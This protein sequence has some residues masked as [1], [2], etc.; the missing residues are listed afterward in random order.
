MGNV[1]LCCPASDEGKAP[2]IP[3]EHVLGTAATE[4]RHEPDKR[5]FVLRQSS[6]DSTWSSSRG[7]E[8]TSSTFTRGFEVGRALATG[9]CYVFRRQDG[10]EVEVSLPPSRPAG[11]N[12]G[13]RLP[14]VVKAVAGDGAAKELGVEV[15][16]ILVQVNGVP[17]DELVAR[18]P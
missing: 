2:V 9:T 7:M 1:E 18:R 11:I 8:S 5:E 14:L 12:F 4:E 17:V 6:V 15:G 13:K 16:W 10:S 3:T